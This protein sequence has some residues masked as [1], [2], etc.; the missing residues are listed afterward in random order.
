[1]A[2][3][4]KFNKLNERLKNLSAYKLTQDSFQKIIQQINAQEDTLGDKAKGL[5]TVTEEEIQEIFRNAFN[6]NIYDL[7]PEGDAALEH[8]KKKYDE[9]IDAI[10]KQIIIKIRSLLGSAKS[11]NEMF[12]IF[13]KFSE[14]MKRPQFQSSL[15]EYQDQFL[16]KVFENSADLH[17]RYKRKANEG[18]AKD[19]CR[20]YGLY[21]NTSSMI[22]FDQVYSHFATNKNKIET[23]MGEKFKNSSKEQEL[24]GISVNFQRAKE[25]EDAA[26][27][28]QI[29]DKDLEGVLLRIDT[30]S[31]MGINKLVVN[32]SEQNRNT[33]EDLRFLIKNK[34]YGTVNLTTVYYFKK[35]TL[36]VFLNALKLFEIV[37]IW[38]HVVQK[39]DEKARDADHAPQQPVQEGVRVHRTGR[40]A[41]VDHAGGPVAGAGGLPGPL[42]GRRAGPG[43][44]RRTRGREPPADRR[45]HQGLGVHRLQLRGVPEERQLHQ[46]IIDELLLKEYTHTEQIV[47]EINNRIE[48]VFSKRLSDTLV[49]WTEEFSKY[50]N[51]PRSKNKNKL[52]KSPTNFEFSVKG[53]KIFIE[54]PIQQARLT[55]LNDLHSHIHTFTCQ[56]KILVNRYNPSAAST[57]TKGESLDFTDLLSKM[58]SSVIANA[59]KA[60][61]EK[62]N[63]AENYVKRWLSYEALWDI[64]I[65]RFYDRFGTNLKTWQQVLSEI[66]AGR[67]TFDTSQVSTNYGPIVIN[68]KAVQ[69]KI[70]N[71]YDSLHKQVLMEF[72]NKF[73]SNTGD[74][75]AK[76]TEYKAKLE[77][78]NFG[79]ASDLVDNI[80]I[81][82][83]CAQ[84][85]EKWKRG[86]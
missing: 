27:K 25:N 71:V 74:I 15:S 17:S 50:K 8:A 81:M 73:V 37:K 55:W 24:E 12:T 7:S 41:G 3:K 48:R 38:N 10:E 77:K 43:T 76:V 57:G 53:T 52:I 5:V 46:E 16:K 60:L 18:G 11:H 84:N 51:E 30:P 79:S 83:F 64:D 19:I 65:K 72:G 78:L 28:I 2:S 68:Y 1:V 13:S 26:K 56:K 35:N 14:I 33:I 70:N 63:S 20:Y 59:Y 40:Q 22:R 69:N 6:I 86:H 32:F 80:A 45:E 54:P 9:K 75:L 58:N 66:K 29:N 23:V 36:S 44:G 61:H 85:I 49:T 82:K 47:R 67:N 31:R 42:P 34:Q 4:L 62:V 39:I 21:P